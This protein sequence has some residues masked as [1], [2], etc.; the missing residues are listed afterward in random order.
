MKVTIRHFLGV[1]WGIAD[2]HTKLLL[3]LQRVDYQHRTPS[4][5]KRSRPIM[6]SRHHSTFQ[7]FVGDKHHYVP[8]TQPQ[9]RRHKP[10]H[11]D[12]SLFFFF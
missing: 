6:A 3:N 1:G 9:E 8:G 12:K 10:V 5:L 7:L 4:D 11:K 2:E